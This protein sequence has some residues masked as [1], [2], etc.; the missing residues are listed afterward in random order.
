MPFVNMLRLLSGCYRERSFRVA[1]APC[2]LMTTR[3]NP[4]T[5]SMEA[6]RHGLYL[7]EQ[8]QARRMLMGSSGVYRGIAFACVFAF[9]LVRRA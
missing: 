3:L 5:Y 7:A 8:R 1:G 9:L 6:L 4:L 2:G